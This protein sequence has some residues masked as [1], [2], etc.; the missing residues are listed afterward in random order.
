MF[1]YLPSCDSCGSAAVEVL[2]LNL[3]R[4]FVNARINR[5]RKFLIERLP[6]LSAAAAVAEHGTHDRSH[7]R[8]LNDGVHGVAQAARWPVIQR[9]SGTNP[10]RRVTPKRGSVLVGALVRFK[11]LAGHVMVT[12]IVC[13]HV[14]VNESTTSHGISI[15]PGDG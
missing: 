14:S 15:P 7:A 13:E 5:T 3:F 1:R 6:T 11:V 2:T 10:R 8:G 9:A 12:V 4:R